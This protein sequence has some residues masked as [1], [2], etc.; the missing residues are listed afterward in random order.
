MAAPDYR[1]DGFEPASDGVEDDFDVATLFDDMYTALA[2]HHS[3]D[4]HDSFL[5]FYD[6]SAIWDNVP[7]TAEYVGMH[8]E[9]DLG[10]R[11]FTFDVTRQP[12]VPLTQSWLVTRG[13]PPEEI[14]PDAKLGPRPADA[15]T[16]RLE[17]RLRTNPDG[18]YTLL[19]HYTYNPGRFDEGVEVRVILHDA[20]PDAADRPYRLFL[21]ETTPSFATYTVREGAFSTAED[22]DTWV[23]ERNGPLPLAPQPQG[24]L[25]R[26]AAA[27]RSR[28]TTL[29]TPGPA[30]AAPGPAPAA[31]PGAAR[32]RGGRS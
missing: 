20:H 19:D 18:R 22:A 3:P 25:G 10:E 7:G 30:T 28:T 12:T 2:A 21:E 27:A 8:F 14:E 29:A 24:D 16:T 26:R 15:L 1:I 6:R 31:A 23:Q 11:T 9:R 17:D 32:S 13:C 5:L 4:G